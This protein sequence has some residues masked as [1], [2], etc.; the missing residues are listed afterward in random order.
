MTMPAAY[1]TPLKRRADIAAYLL[2]RQGRY[3]RDHGHLLFCFCVKVHD[4][5]LDFDHLLDLYRKSGYGG[6]T[7]NDPAWIEEAGQRHAETDQDDLFQWAI[8]DA[9]RLVTESDCF[10]HLYDGTP[11]E[12]E[13]AFVGRSGG[14]IA[15]TE[16]EGI[17]MTDPEVLRQ[18]L[19]GKDEES[20][21]TMSYQSLR[22]LYALVRMLE[23]DL[24]QDKAQAETEH[25]AAFNYFSNLCADIPTADVCLG[26]GI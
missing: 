4:P 9:G 10:N 11:V 3:Y 25:Q 17:K 6:D 22:H 14:W 13:F 23:H 5:D 15:L 18:V 19:E 8:Q 16:F 20:E 12:V 1:K 24:T 21:P 26:A 2:N 7:L